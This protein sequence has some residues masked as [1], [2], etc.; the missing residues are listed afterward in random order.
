[1][2]GS[3]KK[4]ID[5]LVEKRCMKALQ[6]NPEYLKMQIK[7]AEAYKNKEYSE[8]S[9]LVASLQAIAVSTCYKVGTIDAVHIFVH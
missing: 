2:E 1:M 7:C 6:S 5:E 4:D 8:Y 9:D 3:L